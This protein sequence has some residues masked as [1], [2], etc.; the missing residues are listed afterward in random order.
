MLDT[1]ASM[2]ERL[3]EDLL[4]AR[5]EFRAYTPWFGGCSHA[6]TLAVR[7]NMVVDVCL[8]DAKGLIGRARWLARIA[9]STAVGGASSYKV[10]EPAVSEMFGSTDRASPFRI[11]VKPHANREELVHK[12]NSVLSSILGKPA[13]GKARDIVK[14]LLE[15][16]EAGLNIHGF[17]KLAGN[18]R[19][20]LVSIKVKSYS[21]AARKMPLPP[22][23]VKGFT[24][25][26]AWRTGLGNGRRNSLK[27]MASLAVLAAT[28]FLAGLGGAASRGFG[29]FC[30][31][32][33]RVTGV[34]LDEELRKLL[35]GLKCSSPKPLHE[36][37]AAD[38]ISTVYGIIAGKVR[39]VAS[40][41]KGGSKMTFTPVVSQ[42]YIGVVAL[43]GDVYDAL[44]SISKA[45]TK[46]C[47]KRVAR[48]GTQAPGSDLHTWPL[49]LPRQQK[50]GGYTLASNVKQTDCRKTLV[51][52]PGRRLSMIHL[53]PLPSDG[54]R[55]PVVII[56][57]LAYDLTMLVEGEGRGGKLYHVGKYIKGKYGGKPVFD[58]RF[59]Y[60]SIDYIAANP[61]K[62]I[63]DPCRTRHS[64]P[65]GLRYPNH[66]ATSPLTGAKLV[67][68]AFK[69]AFD[70]VVRG[71]R[72]G[73]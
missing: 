71:L 57:Y 43:K 49:G 22:E 21:D 54:T 24:L 27:A 72:S 5:L 40:A 58:K 14:N 47:W 35:E 19:L 67:E 9:L 26:L 34:E 60:V 31:Y 8:P 25:E 50:N 16:V 18:A 11:T 38:F 3:Y 4:I 33:Y 66:S 37:E 68:E 20:G 29:R 61:G 36:D 65:G 69:A 12:L 1:I 2:V 53:Y 55:T 51:G 64:E 48:L 39:R 7:N 73:C 52:N 45:V 56:G 28:P 70:F 44:N 32:D 30:L 59:H 23:L 62:R 10:V 42:S 17:S 6:E 13:P 15:T 63:P 46:Q 41:V